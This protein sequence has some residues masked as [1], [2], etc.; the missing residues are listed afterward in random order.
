MAPIDGQ[1]VELADIKHQRGTPPGASPAPWRGVNTRF[2]PPGGYVRMSI[3]DRREAVKE[4]TGEG[5]STRGIAAVLGVGETTVRRLKG[6]PNG[7]VDEDE[8]SGGADAA[9][10]ADEKLRA[11]EQRSPSVPESRTR[12]AGVSRGLRFRSDHLVSAFRREER[13]PPARRECYPSKG[14]GS[15]WR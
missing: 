11:A 14:G 8:V 2:R 9:L 10:A 15:A 13:Y 1:H 7:A 3:A 12:A 6:A 5:E 4:L